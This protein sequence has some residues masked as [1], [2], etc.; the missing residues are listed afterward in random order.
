MTFKDHQIEFKQVL[1][2]ALSEDKLIETAAVLKS[3]GYY[4]SRDPQLADALLEIDQDSPIGRKIRGYASQGLG[5]FR[6]SR[7]K[8]VITVSEN[9]LTPPGYAKT[10]IGG[11]IPESDLVVV[12]PDQARPIQLHVMQKLACQEAAVNVLQ[13][14]VVDARELLGTKQPPDQTGGYGYQTCT[15]PEPVL[16]KQG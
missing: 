9:G 13:I 12:G 4:S 3:L 15:H 14:G 5:L 8:V 2:T 7:L 11:E 10:C 16:P 6:P 1:A